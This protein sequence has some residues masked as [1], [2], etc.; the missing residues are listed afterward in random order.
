MLRTAINR[1]FF[2]ESCCRCEKRN[3]EVGG[4]ANSYHRL[5]LGQGTCAIDFRVDP[6]VKYDVL[7][8]ALKIGFYGV[9]LNKSTIH[10]DLRPYEERSA[11]GY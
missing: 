7:A 11:W 1:P 9:G 3:D 4:V 10:L 8:L 5:D 2:P 6:M